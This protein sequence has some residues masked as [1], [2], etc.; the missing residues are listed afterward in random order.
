MGR[1][2]VNAKKSTTQPAND[3]RASSWLLHYTAPFWR[4][5]RGV[6]GYWQWFKVHQYDHSIVSILAH[7]RLF[8][9]WLRQSCRR[10]C[11]PTIAMELI[12]PEGTGYVDRDSS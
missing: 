6:A 12:S 5:R 8:R 3:G 11:I 2:R 10:L 7:F 9:R 4:R 1:R